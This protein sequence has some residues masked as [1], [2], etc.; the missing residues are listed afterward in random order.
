MSPVITRVAAESRV[1]I[2]ACKWLVAR[3]DLVIP[4]PDLMRLVERVELENLTRTQITELLPSMAVLK[5][6]PEKS[7]KKGSKK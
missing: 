7:A 1:L 4:D 3:P 6:R 2:V 5:A